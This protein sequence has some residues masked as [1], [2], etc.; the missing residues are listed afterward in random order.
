MVTPMVREKDSI[1]HVV[2]SIV[3]IVMLVGIRSL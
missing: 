1:G 2:N 3:N